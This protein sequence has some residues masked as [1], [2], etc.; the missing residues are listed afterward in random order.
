VDIV[1]PAL[2]INSTRAMY[3]PATRRTKSPATIKNNKN[4][5]NDMQDFDMYE[6]YLPHGM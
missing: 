3:Q 5:D 4:K 1:T 2:V 6:E